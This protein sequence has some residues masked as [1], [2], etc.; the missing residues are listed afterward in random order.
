MKTN[1]SL[2]II[3]LFFC[4]WNSAYCQVLSIG[5]IDDIVVRRNPDVARA[6]AQ[7]ISARATYISSWSN[8]LPR[9]SFSTGM[10]KYDRNQAYFQNDRLVQSD[11]SYS[12]SLSANIS[13]FSGGQDFISLRKSSISEQIAKLNYEDTRAKIVYEA[14]S[15]YLNLLKSTLSLSV[16]RDALGRTEREFNFIK[17]KLELGTAAQTDYVKIEVQLT[18][19]KFEYIQAQNNVVRARESL[20]QI[21][22]FPLDSVFDIDTTFPIPKEGIPSLQE[23]LDGAYRMNR[24]KITSHLSVKSAKLDRYSSWLEYLPSVNVSYG[25]SWGDYELPAGFGRVIDDGS[26]SWRISLSWSIFS[27]T[28]RIAEIIRASANLDAQRKQDE[29]TA[30]SVESLVREL[31]RTLIEAKARYELAEAQERSAKLFYDITEERY[32]LGSATV[33]ELVDAQIAL[34]QAQNQKI[35]AAVD[36][37]KALLNIKLIC[38]K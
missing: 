31:H 25:W 11:R 34:T 38:G 36:F 21:L 35:D 26:G 3:S 9:A 4:L 23:L 24:Q 5:E 18:Q 33:L 8:F 10:N 7:Y 37:Q 32:H 29:S 2:V 19:K 27:G 22:G 15:A 6:Y 28:S 20:A 14:K 30:R 17:Q 13:L 16:S 12:L 1:T